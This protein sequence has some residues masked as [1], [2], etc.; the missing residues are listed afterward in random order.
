MSGKA[1]R[2]TLAALGVI[3]GLVF[4]GW[5]IR[6]NTVATRS[7]TQQALFS[8]TTEMNINVMNNER[9]RELRVAAVDDPVGLERTAADEM[10]LL[11]F[12][13]SRFNLMDNAYYHFTEGTLSPEMWAGND[14]WI[15][16]VI[17]DATHRHY[18]AQLRNG[19]SPDFTEYIDTLFA[20]LAGN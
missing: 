9:L 7:A 17:N 20:E 10:L 4:V 18:W 5:E 19:Y 11:H 1:I 13:M 15:R 12:F 8:A 2:E 14:G 3:A 16:S 6:L